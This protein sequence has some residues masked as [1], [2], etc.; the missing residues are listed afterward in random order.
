M[1]EESLTKLISRLET[2]T[3]R[4]ESYAHRKDYFLTKEFENIDILSLLPKNRF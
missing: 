3:N 2:V 1:A 4:L